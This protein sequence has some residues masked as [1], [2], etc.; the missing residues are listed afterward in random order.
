MALKKN[1]VKF[2]LNKVHWAKITAWS[3]DGVPTFATPVR[4]PGAVSLSVDAS[5]GADNF[6]ADNGV[7]Y[8]INNNSGYEGDLEVALITTDFATEILGEQL[9]SKGVLVERNDAELAQFALLFEFEGDKNKIRHVLYCCSASRPAT[10]SSTT[11]EETEVK[12][13]TLSL[14][15]TALPSGLVKS[16]TCENTDE[17][18]YNNWY[19]AVYIPTAAAT[20]STTNTRSAST[21]KSSTTTTTD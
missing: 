4:L 9:D 18:T 2:G 7:Y 21:A 1:K 19:N 17:T 6:Y 10:E 11:E 16:K 3:D 12:T 14:K 15:A 13:E 20:N 5:G 8:V